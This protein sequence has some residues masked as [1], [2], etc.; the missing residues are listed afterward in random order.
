VLARLY[1]LRRTQNPA[2]ELRRVA[3]GVT[4]GA[5]IAVLASFSLR[6]PLSRGWIL[7][8][9][10]AALVAVMGGRRQVRKSVHHLRRRGRLRRRVLI[11]GADQSGKDL[12]TAVDDAPW[13]GIDVQGFVSVGDVQ[14]S[15]DGIPVVGDIRNLRDLSASLRVSEVLVAPTVAGNGHMRDVVAALDGVPVDL[16]VASG[17][18]GFFPSHMTVGPLG[19]HALLS[20][21]RI[22]LRP[23]ARVVKRAIDLVVGSL[24][25]I[26]VAPV[27]GICVLAVRLDSPG[28]A[29]FRQRRIG[30]RGRPFVMCKLR[31]M[32][33]DAEDLRPLLESS[34]EGHGLLFKIH[35]DPRITRV[36]RF[37]RRTSLDELP[38][39]V[40]VLA[41][42]MSLVGP[43]PPLPTEVAQYD[44]H[45]GRR[46]LVKPGITGLWQ[47]SGRGNLSFREY[48]RYDLM[49]VQN[50]S[51]LLDLYIMLKTIPAV[52]SRN[53]AY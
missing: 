42:H 35:L 20:I 51:I 27:I 18:Q 17:V 19:D 3:H 23:L 37:L 26:A 22:E 14:P 28:P 8:A 2:E 41:G 1:D 13:E 21:E 46:L 34:N 12:A 9:W 24:L 44:D 30:E 52:L 43:R 6:F 7:L 16:K 29:F 5:A 38:Q 25:L 10:L 48:V 47:V 45:L 33:E 4:M 32:R 49:Y 36:G 40:N 53:G 15:P 50:W 31:T 39:L 11:I